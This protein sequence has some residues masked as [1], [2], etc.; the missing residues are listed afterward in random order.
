MPNVKKGFDMFVKFSC[1]TSPRN[2]YLFTNK[3]MFVP[4]KTENYA[5]VRSAGG[6]FAPTRGEVQSAPRATG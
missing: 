4:A 1:A 5:S 3:D 6:S 2:P